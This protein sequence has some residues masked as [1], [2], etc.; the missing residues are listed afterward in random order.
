SFSDTKMVNGHVAAVGT[1][2][3]HLPNVIVVCDIGDHNRSWTTTAIREL[4]RRYEGRVGFQMDSLKASLNTAYAGYT[5][6]QEAAAE[7]HHAG[8]ETVGPSLTNRGQPIARFGGSFEE[9][10]AKADKTEA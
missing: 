3:K 2:V 10:I 6:I 5:R 4:K 9:A 7:G 1:L 8:F